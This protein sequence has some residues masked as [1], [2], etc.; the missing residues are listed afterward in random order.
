M[1]PPS[2]AYEKSKDKVDSSADGKTNGASKSP[3]KPASN[4]P[5][6]KASTVEMA[7]VYIK[8]LQ[9]ELAETKKKLQDAELKLKEKEN[10]PDTAVV[11]SSTEV[12][13]LVEEAKVPETVA[14]P[15]E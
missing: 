11:G 14:K 13:K 6:S 7:I 12:E 4:Q 3:D 9:T 10:G 1:L 2:L 15:L 8:S 5:I